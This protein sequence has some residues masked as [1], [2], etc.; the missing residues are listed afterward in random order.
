MDESSPLLPG[1][2]KEQFPG[3]LASLLDLAPTVLDIAGIQ[4]AERLD[5]LSLL[6]L[7][8]SET[9]PKHRPVL[10][11]VWRHMLPNPCIGMV[12]TAS[13]GSHYSYIYNAA[14]DR[15]ELY[16]IGRGEE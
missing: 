1:S 3:A 12:F 14:D 15:D 2:F 13:D 11:E 16:Q 9:R 4:T 7:A 10:F 8:E 6:G 5:G